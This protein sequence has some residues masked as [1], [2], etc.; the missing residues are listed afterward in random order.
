MYAPDDFLK[1]ATECEL[2]AG[3]TQDAGSKASWMQMAIRWHRC[4][5][6]ATNTSLAAGRR[7]REP[8]RNRHAAPTW[9]RR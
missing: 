5:A 1:R 4:A 3:Q 2:I 9:A 6:M 8:T 7:T